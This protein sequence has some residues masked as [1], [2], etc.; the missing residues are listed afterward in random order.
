LSIKQLKTGNEKNKDKFPHSC[1]P[2]VERERNNQRTVIT[3]YRTSKIE[4]YWK[5]GK[6]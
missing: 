2:T 3:G 4:K 6:K 5:G 1:S